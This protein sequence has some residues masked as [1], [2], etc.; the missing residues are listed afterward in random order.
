MSG[1]GFVFATV[2]YYLE[3]LNKDRTKFSVKPGR[4]LKWANPEY[5]AKLSL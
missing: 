4:G 5:T 1:R 2:K 3:A